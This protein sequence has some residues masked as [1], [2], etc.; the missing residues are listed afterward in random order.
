M[1]RLD[2]SNDDNFSPLSVNPS[3]RLPPKADTS[4]RVSLGS[5]AACTRESHG[6]GLQGLR[7]VVEDD[8]GVHPPALEH[9]LKV[10]MLSSGPPRASRKAY[11]LPCPD[12][13]SSPDKVF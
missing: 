4:R 11:H 3:S 2:D 8:V 6:V 10:Q 12:T 5:D 1:L 9:H 7:L 13:L